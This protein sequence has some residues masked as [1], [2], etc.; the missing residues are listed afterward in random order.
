METLILGWY[1]LVETRSVF[2]LTLYVSLQNLG[3]LIA[4]MLGVVGDRVGPRVLLAGLRLSYAVLATTL[5]TVTFLGLLTPVYVF[6]IAALMGLVRP[7]DM[8]VRTALVG[9]TVPP[10]FFVGAIS[11]QRTTHDSARIFGA[12]TGA[13]IVATLGM[14]PAYVAIA[15]LYT[16]SFL[17]TLQARGA[18][19]APVAAETVARAAHASPLREL[20]DGFR[21]VWSTPPLLGTMCLAFL[22]NLTAFPLLYGLQPYVAK[23]IYGTDQTG[24]GYMIAGASLGALIGSVVLS[25]YGTAVRAGRLMIVACTAWYV[26]LLLFAHMTQPA[27]GIPFLFLAGLAQSV[28]QVPMNALLLRHSEGQIRGRVMGLRMLVIYGNVPGLLLAGPLIAA[29]GYP[30]MATIYCTIGVAFTLLIAA[31][32]RTHLWRRDAPANRR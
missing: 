9:T 25:R 10:V 27:I 8:G 32:W 2:L 20:K 3:T 22:V 13:G 4:P 18:R 5:M 19:P 28:S 24:L 11:I 21:Y 14:A 26:L 17:L 31:R 7:S 16:V 12:L 30:G 29:F 6:G 1:V 23:Q 15:I